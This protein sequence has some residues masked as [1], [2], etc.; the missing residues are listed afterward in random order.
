MFHLQDAFSAEHLDLNRQDAFAQFINSHYHNFKDQGISAL[1]FSYS[2]TFLIEALSEAMVSGN[3]KVFDD[4]K[5][6]C[7]YQVNNRK[8]DVAI[9][10]LP[11]TLTKQE[12]HR[13][14]IREVK[15]NLTY[16]SYFDYVIRPD[17][18]KI[19]DVYHTSAGLTV[20]THERDLTRIY[21]FDANVQLLSKDVIT[22]ENTVYREY[23]A[24]DVVDSK[25]VIRGVERQVLFSMTGLSLQPSYFE[26]LYEGKGLSTIP[27]QFKRIQSHA[28]A[29]YPAILQV[30]LNGPTLT[31]NF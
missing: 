28:L 2:D 7:R 5:I 31:L 24:L 8:L 1:K 21:R 23:Y 6:Q 16:L 25:Y 22:E 3:Y 15:S 20:E 10:N 18:E 4:V 11:P 19:T 26:I 14:I 17:V 27:V 12:W 13:K 29:D 30:D 9:I